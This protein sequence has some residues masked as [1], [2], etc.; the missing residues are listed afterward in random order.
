M[1]FETANFRG[2][3]SFKIVRFL[4]RRNLQFGC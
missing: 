1:K 3:D 2:T 4:L